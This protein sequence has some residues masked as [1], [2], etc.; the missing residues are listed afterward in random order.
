MTFEKAK[1][2]AR[3]GIK[4]T[5]EYFAD[6]EYLTIMGNIITFEDGVTIFIDEWVKDKPW[7]SDGWSIYGK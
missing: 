5:H 1:E 3:Q 2:L 7:T 6:N 4:V